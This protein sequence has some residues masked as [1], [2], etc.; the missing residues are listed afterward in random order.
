MP[1]EESGSR[2]LLSLISWHFSFPGSFF[3]YSSFFLSNFVCLFIRSFLYFYFVL[4]GFYF[5][6]FYGCLARGSGLS[7]LRQHVGRN[8]RQPSS[9]SL[10]EKM[11][12]CRM[13][14]NV[15]L[16]GWRIAALHVHVL[17]SV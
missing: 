8:R 14:G 12:A 1:I 6:L 5:I 10:Y 17:M 7:G 3:F 4:S 16:H 15:Y 13:G 9:V 2:N 11:A